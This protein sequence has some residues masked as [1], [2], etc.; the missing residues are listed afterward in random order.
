MSSLLSFSRG[1]PLKHN[2]NAG[3][4]IIYIILIKWNNLWITHKRTG[5]FYSGNSANQVQSEPFYAIQ[6][7]RKSFKQTNRLCMKLK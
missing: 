2:Q 7:K 3:K 6:V 1:G 4:Q 5:S